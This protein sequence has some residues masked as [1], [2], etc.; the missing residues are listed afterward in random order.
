MYTMCC[1]KVL[2]RWQR[3]LHCM[4][5]W[6]VRQHHRAVFGG[7]H[8]AMSSRQLRCNRRADCGHLLRPLRRGVLLPCRLHH[9]PRHS[10]SRGSVQLAGLSCLH[11][12]SYGQVR[13]HQR[14]DDGAVH[15]AVCGRNV[16]CDCGADRH[17]VHCPVYRG[18]LLPCRL[19][20][21]DAAAVCVGELQHCGGCGVHPLS[22]RH[23]RQQ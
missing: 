1:R 13:Q 2:H 5:R 17:N 12:V 4:R 20:V 6:A 16:R 14:D 8:G 21:A 10:V 11:T 18:V 7:L 22:R 3:E 15:R 19:H 23:V 9:V